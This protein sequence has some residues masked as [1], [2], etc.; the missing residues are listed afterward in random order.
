MP[1]RIE[2]P[3]QPPA[4]PSTPSRKRA[5]DADEDIT[6]NDLAPP[7]KRSKATNNTINDKLFSPSKKR[8]LE[9]DGLLILD[10]PKEEI[11]EDSSNMET[12]TID[13]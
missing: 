13:D 6:G 12:I 5:L 7:A 3:T 8:R 11:G 1:Y 9:E 4:V 10:N 2:K